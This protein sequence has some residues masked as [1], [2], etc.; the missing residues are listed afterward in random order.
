VMVAWVPEVTV[1]GWL[2]ESESPPAA[3]A[4]V[5]VASVATPE[6]SRTASNTTC[7]Y[8]ASLNRK[9]TEHP[10]RCG[11]ADSLTVARRAGRSLLHVR[12]QT[13]IVT[14]LRSPLGQLEPGRPSGIDRACG[15]APRWLLS[16]AQPQ[17]ALRHKACACASTFHTSTVGISWGPFAALFP[18]WFLGSLFDRVDTFDMDLWKKSRQDGR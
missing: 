15:G 18:S 16:W 10:I 13:V 8:A 7:T 4:R 11:A 1:G 14:Q 9:L 6:P 12:R 5:E 17:D 2:T 3:K